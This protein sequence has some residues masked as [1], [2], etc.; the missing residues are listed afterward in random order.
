MEECPLEEKMVL[1]GQYEGTEKTDR[2]WGK[3]E[4]NTHFITDIPKRRAV[5]MKEDLLH[6]FAVQFLYSYVTPHGLKKC[7]RHNS[8]F[9]SQ[10]RTLK[11]I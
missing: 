2:R 4:D 5:K 11:K 1:R 7:S 9:G 3:T 8:F 10:N 6:S